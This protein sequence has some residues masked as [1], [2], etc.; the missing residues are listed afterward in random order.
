[1]LSSRER[2]RRSDARSRVVVF[3]WLEQAH[4]ADCS[5]DLVGR[6]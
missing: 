3:F 5:A 4:A 6:H 2:S 1:M